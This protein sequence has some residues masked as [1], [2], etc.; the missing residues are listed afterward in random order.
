MRHERGGRRGAPHV[1][2]AGRTYHFCGPGC[3]HAFTDS[4]ARYLTDG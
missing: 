3:A 4:P 2:H 1:T